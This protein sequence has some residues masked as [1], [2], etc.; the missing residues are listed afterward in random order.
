MFGAILKTYYAKQQN[1]EPSK[2]FVVSVMPCIAKKYKRQREEMK[3]EVDAVITTREL[4]RMIKQ[5]KI[6]FVNLEDSKF[7]DPMGEATGAAAI[8]GV[9]GGV[10]EAA[11]RSVSEIVTGK[12]LQKIEFEQVRGENGIKKAEIQLENKKVK[13]AVADGLANAKTIMEEIKNGTADYQFVEIMACPGGCI[14]GGGQ[15][16]KSAKI[17][18]EIDV[19]KKR[20]QAMYT[21]DEKSVIRKSHE[22]PVLKQIY[23]KFLGEPN[24]ELA[25]KL[26]HTHYSE[27]PKYKFV[28]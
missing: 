15:P 23:E 9:T 14:T 5:A 28:K 8:F 21:I 17:Q 22:N 25:H 7:D 20:A 16:I 11:L 18:E 2:M 13:V 24:G 26:L 3:Q 6:D 12:P 10:M 1:I 19:H 4:A 27:K